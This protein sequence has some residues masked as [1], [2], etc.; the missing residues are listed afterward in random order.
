MTR[1][2]QIDQLLDEWTAVSGIL[3][4]WLLVREPFSHRQAVEDCQYI[5]VHYFLVKTITFWAFFSPS[6]VLSQEYI[7]EMGF[8]GFV[9]KLTNIY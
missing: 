1:I 2:H 3:F 4:F 9:F 6:T 7:S 8:Q 5:W